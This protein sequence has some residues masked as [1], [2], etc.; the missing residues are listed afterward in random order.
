MPVPT[1]YISGGIW[2]GLF[3]A[4]ILVEIYYE[5]WRDL[6]TAVWSFIN[7]RRDIIRGEEIWTGLIGALILA[8]RYGGSGS[9]LL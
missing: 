4:L 1:N 6:E 5:G 8:E 9:E 3:R 7:W 2:R